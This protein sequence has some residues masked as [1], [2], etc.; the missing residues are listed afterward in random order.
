M[1][2]SADANQPEI[3]NALRRVGASVQHLHMVGGGCPD[4]LVGFRGRN[5]LLEIKT[6]NKKLNQR[7]LEWFSTWS[8]KAHV[9]RTP[10]EAL[11]TIGALR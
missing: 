9:V 5:F 11:R 8:G 7:Q 4:I 3:V 6:R 10:D 2:K 1:I